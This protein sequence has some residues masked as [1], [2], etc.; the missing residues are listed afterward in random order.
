MPGRIEIKNEGP[1]VV[2]G[3]EHELTFDEFGRICA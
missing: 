1:L 3:S 2:V